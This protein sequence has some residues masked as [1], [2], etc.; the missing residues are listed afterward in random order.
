MAINDNL[1]S[2]LHT[3]RKQIGMSIPRLASLTGMADS[4]YRRIESGEVTAPSP[5]RLTAIATALDM[6]ASDLFVAA[7]WLSPRDMPTLRPYMRTK[8][9]LTAEAA[10]AIDAEF[11]EIGRK[12]GIQ[13]NRD[14]DGPN[15]GE[16][17]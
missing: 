12:Y 17:E 1:S 14:T 3:R 9:N 2:T 16:D 4:S 5:E 10:A 15:V 6:P 11:N 8:Y 7:G 13:F